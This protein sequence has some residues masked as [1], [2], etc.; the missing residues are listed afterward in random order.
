MNRKCRKI[1]RKREL[2]RKC[3]RTF[4]KKKIKGPFQNQERDGW[5]A[6]KII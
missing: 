2:R 5:T 1:A 3:L 6:L 4:Q